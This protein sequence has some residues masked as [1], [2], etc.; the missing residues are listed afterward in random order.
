MK[1]K[2]H[3]HAEMIKAWADGAVIQVYDQESNTWYTPRRY[4]DWCET[5]AFRVKPVPTLSEAAEKLVLRVIKSARQTPFQHN[6]EAAIELKTFIL[7]LEQALEENG[8]KTP[9]C[10]AT[11][12]PSNQ[13]MRNDA[14]GGGSL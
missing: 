12:A 13:D 6:V 11:K 7:T 8:I 5:E 4:I 2:P 9:S 10:Q 3:K 14:A 1:L